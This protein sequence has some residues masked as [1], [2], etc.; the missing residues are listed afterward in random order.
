MR[1]IIR[2]DALLLQCEFKKESEGGVRL[3]TGG[4]N[5]TES[6]LRWWRGHIKP[7]CGSYW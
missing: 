1:L 3:S 2:G 4:V 7:C 6:K 5:R